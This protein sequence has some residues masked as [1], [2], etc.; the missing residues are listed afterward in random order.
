[1]ESSPL[2]WVGIVHPPPVRIRGCDPLYWILAGREKY[3]ATNHAAEALVSYL[4]NRPSAPGLAA[5]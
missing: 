1:M 4:L 3:P 2:T 5:Q